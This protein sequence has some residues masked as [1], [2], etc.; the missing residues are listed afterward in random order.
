MAMV[1]VLFPASDEEPTLRPGAL[2]EL[3]RLGVTNVALLRDG[4]T[5]GLVL[6]G[7]AFAAEAAQQAAWAVAGACDD[8]RTLHP[9]AQMAVSAVAKGGAS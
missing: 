7:W 5:A 8:V 4:S 2:E 1:V 9:L 6:E 3:A